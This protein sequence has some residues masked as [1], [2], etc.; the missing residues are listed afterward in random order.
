MLEFSDFSHG[1]G[2]DAQQRTMDCL[3]NNE[4]Q[5]PYAKN[6]EVVFN[7]REFV[8]K[9]YIGLV[10]S[11]DAVTVVEGEIPSDQED[12]ITII[13]DSTWKLQSGDRS[14]AY[15]VLHQRCVDHIR[16]NKISGVV[17]KASAVPQGSARLALLTSAEVRG[18]LLAAAASVCENTK[19][20]SAASISRNYGDRK[21][22]EYVADDDFWDEVTV[23]GNLRKTSREAAMLLVASKNS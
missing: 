20:L 21:I 8:S 16:E 6:A 15:A 4:L 13:G 3:V 10:A 11:S 5:R 19:E 14:S 7:K 17:V 9:R 12:P 18:V 22:A 1:N 2:P 23:G